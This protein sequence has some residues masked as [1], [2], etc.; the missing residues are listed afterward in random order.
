M[1]KTVAG[2]YFAR[3]N[4]A[5]LE[6]TDPGSIGVALKAALEASREGIPIPPRSVM[7]ADAPSALYPAAGVR[8][9]RDFAKGARS[10][11]IDQADGQIKLT[12]WKN[13]GASGKFVPLKGRDH[14]ILET[15]S[16]AD[17]G[18]AVIAALADAE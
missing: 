12:P 6:V 8:N 7:A 5:A 2:Y 16:D 4:V 10:L 9:W 18:A 14:A 13:E 15:S 3:D 11:W 17:L 1:D